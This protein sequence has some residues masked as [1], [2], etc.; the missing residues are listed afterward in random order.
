MF[1]TI[2]IGYPTTNGPVNLPAFWALGN[3]GWI[4]NY[5]QS[6][7]YN[8]YPSGNSELSYA[9]AQGVGNSS[10]IGNWNPM[11]IG[12]DLTGGSQTDPALIAKGNQ[13]AYNYGATLM[14]QAMFSSSV[15]N[16]TGLESQI[17]NVMKSDDLTDAQKQKLQAILDKITDLKERIQKAAQNNMSTADMEAFQKEIINLNEEASKVAQ[18]IAEE[19]KAAQAKDGVDDGTT[20]S[21]GTDSTDTTDPETAI[22]EQEKK[23]LVYEMSK[24]CDRIDKAVRGLGTNYDDDENGI[25]NILANDIDKDNVLELF[26]SWNNNY[27]GQEPY[28]SGD[29]KNYGL[30]GTLMNDCEGDEKEEI[31]TYLIEALADKAFELGIDVSKEVTAARQAT[32]SNFLGMRDDDKICKAVNALYEKVKEGVSSTEK[33]ATNKKQKTEADKKAEA[34]KVKKDAEQKLEK[35]K[36]EKTIQFRDDMREIL[37]DENAEISD[38]VEYKDGKFVIRIEG[39]NY[40]GKDYLELTEAIQKGIDNGAIKHGSTPEAFLKKATVK[41]AA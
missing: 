18:E 21:D 38:K 20:P 36:Q 33:A 40:Y 30:I 3:R 8:V 15:S 1:N 14:A 19:V 39:K 31:A 7:Q 23:A 4:S 12:L 5:A 41:Q 24:V 25:K 35:E 29:D 16:L 37:G 28:D 11:L 34:D 6:T 32:H 10:H 27:K 9:L 26:D 13:A 2:P 17:T 22:K